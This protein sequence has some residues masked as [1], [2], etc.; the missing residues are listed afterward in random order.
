MR[1]ADL[2]AQSRRL[3]S[4]SAKRP[5]DADLRRAISSAYYA[6][7][8]AIARSG[9]DLLVGSTGAQR[10]ERAWLQVYRALQ[11]GEAKNRCE[12]LPADFSQDLQDVADAFVSLQKL[13]HSADYDIS[14]IF[15]RGDTLNHILMA[16]SAVQKLARS[17]TLDRRA[18]VVW[19][20][21]PKPR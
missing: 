12:A 6:L 17:P 21:F 14:A 13:R 2:L 4:A 9:A 3:A 15:T 16:E 11:H 8:H 20:L 19:L 7:F 10:S 5:R 18:F 1:P